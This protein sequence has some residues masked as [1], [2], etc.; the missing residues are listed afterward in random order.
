MNNE[1][2]REV[3]YYQLLDTYGRSEAHPFPQ[4]AFYQQDRAPPHITCAFR[5]LLEE[6]FPNSLVGRYG[7][8]GGPA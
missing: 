6:M 3:D 2:A 8:I 4:N 5:S 1:K 7:P